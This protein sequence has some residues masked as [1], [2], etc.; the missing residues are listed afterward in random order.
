LSPQT[1]ERFSGVS[2][3]S[4]RT[5]LD[6]G[7]WNNELEAAL[8]SRGWGVGLGEASFEASVVGDL[9]ACIGGRRLPV[10]P[11]VDLV[12][13]PGRVRRRLDAA[14]LLWWK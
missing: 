14:S 11:T 13:A 8:D 10:D 2:A 6:E 5:A 1:P 4:K 9:C 3:F 7:A 12:R